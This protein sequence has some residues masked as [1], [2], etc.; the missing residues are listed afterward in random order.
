[1]SAL[2][3]AAANLARTTPMSL[4][5]AVAAL[6]KPGTA[7][8]HQWTDEWNGAVDVPDTETDPHLFM[9]QEGIT[10]ADLGDALREYRTLDTGYMGSPWA[11]DEVGV[12]AA[13]FINWYRWERL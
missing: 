5:Q 7:Q 3:D 13:D 4:E 2:D 6:S 8:T 10:R 12:L 9:T 1:M 11:M